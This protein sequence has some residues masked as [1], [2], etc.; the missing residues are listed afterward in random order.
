MSCGS[1]AETRLGASSRHKS[2]MPQQKPCAERAMRV[3]SSHNATITT[4]CSCLGARRCCCCQNGKI[5]CP[6]LQVNGSLGKK[7]SV[8]V[9]VSY[10]DIQRLMILGNGG[11]PETWCDFCKLL[12]ACPRGCVV[13][14]VVHNLLL[15]TAPSPCAALPHLHH[16]ICRRPCRH[17]HI[18]LL[19]SASCF[20]DRLAR[21]S[22]CCNKPS[23]ASAVCRHAGIWPG[24]T[25]AGAQPPR[26]P[27]RGHHRPPATHT[28][29]Q[30]HKTASASAAQ[31]LARAR[32]GVALCMCSRSSTRR[33]QPPTAAVPP[34][35]LRCHSG[36][37]SACGWGPNL[38]ETQ[39]WGAGRS[40]PPTHH[41]QQL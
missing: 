33:H 37:T 20:S 1:D 9:H 34:L 31:L 38:Q 23:A 39:A 32:T 19:H 35:T 17:L 11:S 28:H 25:A 24:L 12:T 10:S 29:Q 27:T 16:A 40:P 4:L 5:L 3:K 30:T 22:C 6:G 41:H 14:A 13:A 18:V 7:N 36:C 15:Y 21:H 2:S 8:Y 26:L